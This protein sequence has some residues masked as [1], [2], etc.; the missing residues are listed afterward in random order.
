[1]LRGKEMAVLSCG[2]DHNFKNGFHMPFIES[3]KYLGMRYIGDVHSWLE[4]DEIP[5]EVIQ[6]LNLFVHKLLR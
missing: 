4:D 6:N 1:M 5:E 2:S 3:A